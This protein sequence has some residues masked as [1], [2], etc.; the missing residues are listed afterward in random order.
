MSK[1]RVLIVE[2]M[3]FHSVTFP[4]YPALLPNLLGGD[5]EY[6][7]LV[8]PSRYSQMSNNG[9]AVHRLESSWL[10]YLVSK[11][12]LRKGYY[13]RLIQAWVKKLQVDVVVFNTI[14]TDDLRFFPAI[15]AVA[16]Q[17]DCLITVHN[18]RHDIHQLLRGY[19][20][21]KS[22]CL[23]RFNYDLLKKQFHL[24]GYYTCAFAEYPS[25]QASLGLKPCPRIVIPGEI[26]FRRRDYQHLID[27]AM[28]HPSDVAPQMLFVILGDITS[29]YGQRL[30]A[31]IEQNQLQVYFECVDHRPTDLEFAQGVA[32][33]D[34]VMPVLFS[35]SYYTQGS[36][37]GSVVQSGAYV[38]PLVLKPDMAKHMQLEPGQY[39]C[40]QSVDDFYV[41]LT[42]L[43]G[44]A[45]QS[46][47]R[48][49]LNENLKANRELFQL[50]KL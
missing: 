39:F 34:F 11:L 15:K 9:Y 46:A 48:N 4:L 41:Q 22:F 2:V 35:D 40:Y 7:Y 5:C 45:I 37:S 38:K 23:N 20:R 14:E 3:D 17:C 24:D 27:I 42:C 12:G 43:D 25:V 47:Y 29:K 36:I 30:R 18:V 6:H 49:Y 16:K 1:K 50:I 13:R 33:A 26:D 8:S 10:R 32:D 19:P 21:I 28:Q 44:Q 31:L